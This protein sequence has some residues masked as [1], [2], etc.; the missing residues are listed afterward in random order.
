R[1]TALS[2][3]LLAL[4]FASPAQASDAHPMLAE[5]EHEVMCPT[6]K[7]L[8]ELSHAPV[9]DRM[10]VFIRQRIAAGETK[11]EIKSQLV[12]EFGEGVLAAPRLNGFGLLA[13]LLPSRGSSARPLSSGS[14]R[15]AGHGQ[16]RLSG[17][18]RRVRTPSTLRSSVASTASSPASTSSS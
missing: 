3:V 5:I 10:R 15:G 6:C 7:T 18:Q 9:A 12:A 14:S 17:R 8:L 4:V 13:W 2:L 1:S 11:S 16:R